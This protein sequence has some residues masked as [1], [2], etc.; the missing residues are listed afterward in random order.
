MPALA[1]RDLMEWAPPGDPSGYL[2]GVLAREIQVK[3]AF[4]ANPQVRITDDRPLN[5]YFVLRRLGLHG[6]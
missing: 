1:Q 4:H 2:S 3:T 6:Y 5:E